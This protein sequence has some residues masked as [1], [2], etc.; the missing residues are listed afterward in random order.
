MQIV[1]AITIEFAGRTI[2]GGYS[3][4][5]R[6]ITVW[7]LGDRKTT[8]LGGFVGAPDAL[9]RIMLRELPQDGLDAD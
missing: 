2:S 5:G 8:H 7:G 3:T 9:A 6:L 4:H 1:R